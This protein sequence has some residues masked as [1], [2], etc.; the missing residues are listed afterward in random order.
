MKLIRAASGCYAHYA[1][2]VSTELGVKV[3]RN[4]TKFLCRVNIW[5]CDSTW[6]AGNVGVVV[7]DSIHEKVVVPFTRTVDAEPSEG[8]RCLG[9][10][11]GQKNKIG[12]VSGQKRQVE[13]LFV[14]DNRRQLL[15]GAVDL[16]RRISCADIDSRACSCRI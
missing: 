3:A 8:C 1:T 6:N 14:L 4:Y 7:I 2:R 15:V 16:R 9:R 13:N 5:S 12:G 11:R 10:A